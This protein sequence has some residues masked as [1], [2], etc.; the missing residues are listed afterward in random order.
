L[1]AYVVALALLAILGI[2]LWDWLPAAMDRACARARIIRTI[3]AIK[4]WFTRFSGP[5]LAA[6]KTSSAGPTPTA[7]RARF[8]DLGPILPGH[9][10]PAR[11]AGRSAAVMVILRQGTGFDATFALRPA[12]C[13]AVWRI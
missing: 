13:D 10:L 4:Q 11:R 12:L 2:A 6:A 5:L 9:T 3:P 8:P 7:G 1:I